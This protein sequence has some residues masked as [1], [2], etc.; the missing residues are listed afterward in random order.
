MNTMTCIFE[1]MCIL[2]HHY[3]TIERFARNEPHVWKR[4]VLSMCECQC[5]SN[6]V[7]IK[8]DRGGLEVV[9]LVSTV[10]WQIKYML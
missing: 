2:T 5:V 8:Y 4:F 3:S 7:N 9:V 6:T 10:D 1:Y